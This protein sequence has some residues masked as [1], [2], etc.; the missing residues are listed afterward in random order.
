MCKGLLLFSV[1]YPSL[2]QWPWTHGCT[3]LSTP[4]LCWSLTVPSAW[5]WPT[6]PLAIL[7]PT[8]LSIRN[9]QYT[10][11]NI[12]H[13]LSPIHYD[14][15][16]LADA[17]TAWWIAFYSLAG[18]MVHTVLLTWLALWLPR[19][20]WVCC[21]QSGWSHGTAVLAGPIL[22]Q[23][24]LSPASSLTVM[25]LSMKISWPYNMQRSCDICRERRHIQADSVDFPGKKLYIKFQ[26]E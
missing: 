15:T 11:S 10:I 6:P 8:L 2:R 18:P 26:E 25:R 20:L 17:I 24:I 21:P 19:F 3:S 4:A 1:W 9:M 7:E 13:L 23:L 22:A 5:C 14:S 12:R 16:G